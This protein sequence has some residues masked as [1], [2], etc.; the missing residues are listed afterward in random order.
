M[1]GVQPDAHSAPSLSAQGLKTRRSQ[2]ES[3]V[4][5]RRPVN[6]ERGSRRSPRTGDELLVGGVLRDH[7]QAWRAAFREPGAGLRV[8]HFDLLDQRTARDPG[9]D[10]RQLAVEQLQGRGPQRGRQ[11]GLVQ[12]RSGAKVEAAGSRGDGFRRQEL[13]LQRFDDPQG[14]GPAAQ[15]SQL[16]DQPRGQLGLDR[17]PEGNAARQAVAAGAEPVAVAG[18]R[19]ARTQRVAAQHNHVRDIAV[20][21]EIVRDLTRQEPARG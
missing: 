8:G 5:D 21:G 15:G 12:P 4:R 3:L 9:L 14:D 19:E 1:R 10:Q 7:D 11:I 2:Q 18:Q 6:L 16:L 13:Q 20:P 17:D